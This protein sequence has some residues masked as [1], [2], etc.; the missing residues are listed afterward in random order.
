MVCLRARTKAV[1]WPRVRSKYR[2]VFRS[3][4]WVRLWPGLVLRTGL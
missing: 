3:G 2:D 4:V 1:S